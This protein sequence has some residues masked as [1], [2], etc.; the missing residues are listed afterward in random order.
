MV[1]FVFSLFGVL[2]LEDWFVT[3]LYCLGV[4]LF[5]R[6]FDYALLRLLFDSLF[7]VI[8]FVIDL[9][10]LRLCYL[11]AAVVLV[12]FVVYFVSCFSLLVC[13]TA[14]LCLLAY[15]VIWC[16]DEP[17]GVLLCCYL[18]GTVFVLFGLFVC[19]F[20]LHLIVYFV[21]G[22]LFAAFVLGL[23]FC[24]CGFVVFVALG[25]LWM[26][27]VCVRV[28]VCFFA[29]LYCS[30]LPWLLVVVVFSYILL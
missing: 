28:C 29:Y 24:F 5:V 22:W 15:L 6:Y 10:G 9:L 4:V 3:V 8:L 11:F 30:L 16:L 25:L 27:Y 23:L 2:C 14:I 21:H 26:V 20:P 13:R 18:F 7:V 19:L 12:Y 17:D 1:D